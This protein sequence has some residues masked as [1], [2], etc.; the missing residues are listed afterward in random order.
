MV[1]R[2]VVVRL[3]VEANR[4][5]ADMAS[6]GQVAAQAANRTSTAW[7]KPQSQFGKTAQAVKQNE[8]AIQDVGTA[9]VTAGGLMAGLT[10]GAQKTGV[11]FNNLKQTSQAAMTTLTGS[12]AKA[13]QQ[14]DKLNEFGSN[15]SWVMRDVLL[16]AQQQMVGFGIETQKVIPYMDGLQEAVAATGGSSQDFEEL[17]RVMAKVKSQ[18]K[19]TA[20]TFNEFGSRG[21]DA[22]TIIGEAMG[23][24]A[25]DIRNQV[26]AGTLDADVALDNLAEGMKTKFDG[27]SENVKKTFR[28]AVDNVLAGWRDLSSELASPIVD[29][30]G[31]GL[32]VDGLNVLADGLYKAKDAAEALPGPVKLGASAVG[33][34]G[35]GATVAAG[36]FLL[37]APRIVETISSVKQLQQTMPRTTSAMGKMGKVTGTVAA[38][39]VTAQLAGAA[40]NAVLDTGSHSA[41]EMKNRLAQMNGELGGPTEGTLL[42]PALWEEANGFW[43]K[44]IGTE[45]VE[46]WGQA[47]D[48]AND[49]AVGW[50]DSMLNVE[51]D[52]TII[53][54]TIAQT[55]SALTELAS[56]GS[57]E[58]VTQGF[59]AIVDQSGDMLPEDVLDR[60]PKLKEELTSTATELGLAADD[61]TLVALAMGEI[62][63]AAEAA[64][65]GIEGVGDKSD[66]TAESL[67]DLIGKFNELSGVFISS[68]EAQDGYQQRLDEIDQAIKDNGKNLDNTTEKG[69][70]NRE[71]LRGLAEDGWAVIEANAEMGASQQELSGNFQD[72]YDDLVDT[73]KRMGKSGDD[74]KAYARE[75]MG[76]PGDVPTDV[77]IEE[78]SKAI[79]EAE[80]IDEAVQDIRDKVVQVTVTM[81]WDE[82]VEKFP[83]LFKDRNSQN[84]PGVMTNSNTIAP[85]KQIKP[86]Y[87]GGVDVKGMASGGV[88]DVAEMV[89]PGDIRF[90]G[91]RKDVDEAWIPLDGSKRS[92]KILNEAMARMP[93]YATG[94]ATG[95]IVSAE[96]RL[97]TAQ[98]ELDSIRNAGQK[99]TPE[100]RRRD[101]AQN[102]VDA[103]REALDRAK[104]KQARQ[105]RVNQL[106]DKLQ[107]DLRRGN[108]SD[109]VT[110]S[111]SG[112]QSAIDRLFGLG[113]DEDLSSGSR[114]RASSSARKFESNLTRLY[115]QAESL[116]D[117]IK[118]A[119]DR[120]SELRGIADGVTSGLLGQRSVDVGDYDNFAGGQWTT[121]S[122]VAG[123]T[124][125]MNADV[126]QM[127][128]FAGKLKKLVELGIPGPIVQEIAQ[129]G[130]AEGSTM[131]DAFLDATSAE[132]Q[133]YIGAWQDYEKYASQAGQYVSEGFEA[134]GA[135]AAEG[136]VKGLEGKQK[137]VETA[138]ANLAKSMESTFKQV[139]GIASPS[140]VMTELGAFTSEG[141]ALGILG[142]QG[143][144]EDAAD[145]L[146]A[147]AVP[148]AMAFDVTANP[149]VA[150]DEAMAGLAMQDMS[151]RTLEAM[152]L[153]QVAVS[154]GWASMLLN[155]QE[156]QAGMLTGTQATQAGMVEALMSSWTTQKDTQ[157]AALDSM[158]NKLD[159]SSSTQRDTQSKMLES[160]LSNLTSGMESQRST[161]ATYYNSMNDKQSRSLSLQLSQL[162]DGFN[163]QHGSMSNIMAAMNETLSTRWVSMRST[164]ASELSSMRSNAESGFTVI[165]DFGSDLMGQLSKAVGREMGKVSPETMGAMKDTTSVLNKFGSAANEAF[166]D[167]GVK[168]PTMKF[169]DG[170]V[171][172][173]YSPGRD[174]HQFSSPTAGN[175]F[176]SGGE[177]IMRPEFTRSVGGEAGIKRLNRAARNGTL[178]VGMDTASH[179]F[180]QGGVYRP[181]PGVNAFADSGVWRN[182]WAIHKKQ[183]PNDQ[184]TSAYRGG[185]ITASGNRSHHARG[186]AIDVSPSMGAFDW[187]RSNYGADLA[188]LIYSPGNGRQ[189][190]NGQ[191]HMYTGAVRSMHYNH[192]HIAA[193]KA[194]SE[195]MAGGMPG[196]GGMGMSHP[197]LD[198]GDVKP[199]N[200]LE[201]SYKKAAQNITGNLTDKH[202]ANLPDNLFGQGLGQ[203]IMEQLSGG[204][205][206]KAGAYG[207]D[208]TFQDPGGTGVARWRD[209]VVQ[210]LTRVGLPTNDS[211]VNAWLR[212]IKSE[213]GGNPNIVQGVKDVN[214]GGNEAQGLVQVIPGTFSAF[215][216]PELPNDRTHPLAN[217]VAGMNW[218]KYKYPNMLDVI[219]QG[220]GYATGTPSARRGWNMVGENG[221]EIVGKNG[222]EMRW[223][224]GGETVI[225][226]EE[227]RRAITASS[228]VSSSG[229][230]GI[231]YNR[232]AKAVVD[233]LPP[234]LVVQNDNAGLIEE[235]IAQKTVQQF[236]DKQNLYTMGLR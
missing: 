211:Y 38:G 39:F 208:M 229:A 139:L 5:K 182:L 8:G 232:L 221:W 26:T 206:D 223:F 124:R 60:F 150:D 4:Y 86:K 202:S 43:V 95:G 218:A 3:Q 116:E 59:Q 119:K 99:T 174:I 219:G 115:N 66:E 45:N 235:R 157:S 151:D 72:M 57:F 51:S 67:S 110:G 96:R 203:G 143:D 225:P 121:H 224:D 205:V 236:T 222:P 83:G 56:G 163:S 220:H 162:Q 177:S 113:E 92:L 226:H 227:S 10:I 69:R 142:G 165:R 217:L 111:L 77:Y 53:N 78:A 189:I 213:S 36:G 93:G 192:V 41:E 214:S 184:L 136:V 24:T 126:G 147:S 54:D 190:K 19:I 207:K 144:V 35:G 80:D 204:L 152:Q 90:A 169:A 52:V 106:Q 87:Y 118:D 102:R 209:T 167:L 234:S 9:A 132:Q 191:N 200:D 153:M 133:S 30:S 65:Q 198:R 82:Q 172:P 14:M 44:G 112:G 20:Q 11:E 155:T 114:A 88:M 173:G 91:D 196:G 71:Q 62:D 107:V 101:Q 180:A 103:A 105:D 89:S 183:F 94:M 104:E 216:D 1:D 123:A 230:G 22:A 74:A 84:A 97:T 109:Q 64:A 37:M 130:A 18:G 50:L 159:S 25:D 185:S 179:A 61:S 137:T 158:S 85:P 148:N 70:A 16:R 21:V 33:V 141:F 32:G 131:A 42:D 228:M 140:R 48:R 199:G 17:S 166:G 145:K 15:D 212:Q 7:Q 138:I 135:N 171:M 125:R 2:S 231:D 75:I 117:K 154:E 49:S 29:P 175:L 156:T 193:V 210:A 6:A 187:W 40:F 178:D 188:E 34:L 197:F 129:A 100:D 120:A 55:D 160:M 46:T 181:T 164:Q 13:N 149:V 68:E 176:L 98:K 23:T 146:A 195:A 215:R 201:K 161:H 79:A 63:P 170:G 76:I 168:V 233:N 186:N 122:G 108:I 31:G 128:A 81:D 27:A 194:L 58:E 12:T 28:G 127:K 73:G 47:F 134:G